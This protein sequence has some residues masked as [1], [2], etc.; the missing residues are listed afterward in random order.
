MA[1][2]G[3]VLAHRY[4]AM[5][6]CH[7]VIPQCTATANAIEQQTKSARNAQHVVSPS[8]SLSPS[9]GTREVLSTLI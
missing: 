5:I 9:L 1:E 6:H 3:V 2:D 8:L 7:V 4:Y